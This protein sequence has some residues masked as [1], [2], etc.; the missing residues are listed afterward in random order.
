MLDAHNKYRRMEVT[1]RAA[2]DMLKMVSVGMCWDTLGY[3]GI[4]WD[5]LGYIETS[6]ICW[7]MLG[8]HNWHRR[9]EVT[10]RA[11]TDM[12]KIGVYQRRHVTMRE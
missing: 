3:V 6:W 4:H 11:A 2:T 7:Y 10:D 1:D 12:L 5:M 8:A 9:M